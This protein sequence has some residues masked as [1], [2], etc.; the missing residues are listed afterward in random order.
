MA[1]QPDWELKAL[2]KV[3]RDDVRVGAG[4][5]KEGGAIA[6]SVNG[7]VD[8]NALKDPDVIITLFPVKKR[9]REK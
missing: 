6:I 4:W 1:N 3:T 2:N 7:F 5:S 8:L 9:D